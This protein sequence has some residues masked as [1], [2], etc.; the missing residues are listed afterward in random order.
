MNSIT[1]WQSNWFWS[2]TFVYDSFGPWP[3]HLGGVVKADIF[4]VDTKIALYVDRKW[5]QL[6]VDIEDCVS[7]KSTEN[8]LSFKVD[9]E[10]C[11]LCRSLSTLSMIFVDLNLLLLL[12]RP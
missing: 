7:F 9:F 11:A 5:Q 3:E 1:D 12:C 4:L 2:D 10:N 6:K 8:D